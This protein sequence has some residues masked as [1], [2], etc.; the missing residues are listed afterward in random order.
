MPERCNTQWD[1]MRTL[2]MGMSVMNTAQWFMRAFI[3]HIM[4]K[5]YTTRMAGAIFTNGH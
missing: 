3:N 1:A 2:C 5:V 4:I